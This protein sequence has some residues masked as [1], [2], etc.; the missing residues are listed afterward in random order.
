MP[1]HGHRGRAAHALGIGQHVPRFV[2]D[3]DLHGAGQSTLPPAI[4]R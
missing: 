4:D 1:Q 2:V 3:L